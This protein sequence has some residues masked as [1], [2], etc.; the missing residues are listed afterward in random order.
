MAC[1]NPTHFTRYTFSLVSQHDGI[2]HVESSIPVS[3]I[4]IP[5]L[6]I[7]VN[8]PEMGCLLPIFYPTEAGEKLIARG[9]A[10]AVAVAAANWA[11]IARL[12]WELLDF[13]ATVCA[14]PVTLKHRTVTTRAIAIV[15]CWAAGA[16]AIAALHILPLTRLERKF[17]NLLTAIC[18]L[19][20]T[21]HHRAR[22]KLASITTKHVYVCVRST[23]LT[24][25]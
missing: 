6:Y 3:S 12:E 5:Y 18:T 9:A 15:A 17:R 16:V 25:H 20:V 19:P 11:V 23:K 7:K 8:T 13:L 21:L 14:C 22:G 2:I 1:N 10:I 24:T 4:I